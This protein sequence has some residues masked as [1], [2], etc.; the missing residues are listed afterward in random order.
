MPRKSSL[1]EDDPD[2]ALLSL[3]D[4][5]KTLGTT[6]ATVH[7]MV[8]Q[9]KLRPL[10]DSKTKAVLYVSRADVLR[11]AAASKPR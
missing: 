9:K 3:P 1:S 7:E 2:R 6:V 10:T 5:A 11:L 4:A 8:R